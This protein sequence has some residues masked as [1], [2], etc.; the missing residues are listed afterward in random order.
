MKKVI[1]SVLAFA[2]IAIASCKKESGSNAY[3]CTTCTSTAEALPANDA[4]SKGVYK[5][6]IIGSSGTVKFS[7]QNGTSNIFAFVEIDGDTA[8]LT[9]SIS[10]VSGQSYVAPFTGTLKG[11][12]VSI[13]FSVQSNGTSPVITSASIPGHASASF[14]LVK[15]TSNALVEC[16]EGTYAT[17]LPE[18]GTFNILLSRPLGQWGGQARKSGATSSSDVD[19][20]IVNGN[21]LDEDGKIVGTLS[22]DDINGTFTDNGGN[23]VTITGHRTL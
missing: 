17:T 14:M 12:P 7:I 20:T 5:G 22:G 6:V 19:G 23:T 2:T 4:S 11:Q 21:L 18:T 8:T 13:T 16:F 1:F 3:K 10:W 9:S 15:E